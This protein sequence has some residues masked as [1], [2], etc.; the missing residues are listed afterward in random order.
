ML[1]AQFAQDGVNAAIIPIQASRDHL[2]TMMAAFRAMENLGGL[3]VSHPYKIAA[4][5][6]CDELSARA[7]AVGS[8]NAIR[9]EPDGRLIADMFDGIGFIA[10]LSSHGH[11]VHGRHVLLSG[12]GDAAAAV[13]FALAE[14]NVAS[15]T[16]A[17]Q[18]VAQARDIVARVATLFPRLDIHM[19]S[20]NP[21]GHDLIINTASL[22]AWTRDPAPLDVASLAPGML[23]AETLSTPDE[24]PFLCAAAAKGCTVHYGRYM[25]DAQLRLISDFIGASSGTPD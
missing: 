18:D 20:A 7:E 1:N 23:A 14:S 12:T 24:T 21:A 13:A 3:I 15:M 9:R 6:F 2:G 8:V 25:L 19:G 10:G 4:A 11:R 16:V 22:D 17:G 5:A